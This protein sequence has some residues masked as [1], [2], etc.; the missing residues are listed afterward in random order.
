MENASNALMMAGGILLALLILSL[1]VFTFN[2]INRSENA[3]T[4]QKMI[5]EAQEFNKKFLAFEKSSMYGTDV[6]SILGLAIRS[7][8]HTSELQSLSRI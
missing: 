4:D 7:E 5:Q 1:L 8:E 3:K 6:I 2:I